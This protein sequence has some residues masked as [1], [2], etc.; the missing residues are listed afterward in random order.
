MLAQAT[1]EPFVVSAFL[2]GT[3]FRDE[4]LT[5]ARL[6]LESLGEE[7]CQSSKAIRIHE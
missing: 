7:V 6:E 1:R 3:A 2:S 5:S 4:R